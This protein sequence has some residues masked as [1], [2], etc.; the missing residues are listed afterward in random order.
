MYLKTVTAGALLA[1]ASCLLAGCS[2]HA[3]MP[4]VGTAA[5]KAHLAAPD[6]V[7]AD[8][9]SKVPYQLNACANGPMIEFKLTNTGATPIPLRREDFA[10]VM[11][12]SNRRV[13][14]Y[15]SRSATIEL[16]GDTLAPGQTI[17]GRAVYKEFTEPAGKRLV[18]KPD[19]MGTYADV[20][21]GGL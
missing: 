2:Q 12:G 21:V 10:L 7:A 8:P 17:Q 15:N 1:A 16:P 19:E 4:Q 6:S 11:T 3:N 5:S 13:V 9:V 14:P 18:Y 20:Q